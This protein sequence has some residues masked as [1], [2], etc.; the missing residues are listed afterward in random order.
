MTCFNEVIEAL[1]AAHLALHLKCE[2][3]QR[4]TIHDQRAYEKVRAALTNAG[5]VMPVS[6][7]VGEVPRG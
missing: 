6:P 7:L 4:W 2:S 3:R 1:Q 5:A